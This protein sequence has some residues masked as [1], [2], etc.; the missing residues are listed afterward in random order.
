MEPGLP[1][2]S[3]RDTWTQQ[4][5]LPPWGYRPSHLDCKQDSVCHCRSPDWTLWWMLRDI[6]LTASTLIPLSHAHQNRVE[7]G[8]TNPGS[9]WLSKFHSHA[10]VRRAL[11]YA[12][13]LGNWENGVRRPVGLLAVILFTQPWCRTHLSKEA[14]RRRRAA[15]FR[16]GRCFPGSNFELFCKGDYSNTNDLDK[17]KESYFLWW[18]FLAFP[19]QL[20]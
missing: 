18:S 13:Y 4:C 20:L 5:R 1:S 12:C 17:V 19:L 7:P 3:C 16:K 11:C 6:H 14:A 10:P 8:L 2:Q 15:H 9:T